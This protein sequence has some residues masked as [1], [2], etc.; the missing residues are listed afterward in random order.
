MAV[1]EPVD[2]QATGVPSASIVLRGAREHQLGTDPCRSEGRQLEGAE[3]SVEFSP[4][5]PLP[6]HPT[7]I[8]VKKI[9]Q[10][11]LRELRVALEKPGKM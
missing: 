3:T 4:I 9:G 11:L 7:H 2:A 10:I 5:V 1:W 6:R 8:I